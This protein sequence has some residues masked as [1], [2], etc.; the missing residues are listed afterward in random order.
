MRA[1]PISS[2]GRTR[3]GRR[4]SVRKQR[5]LRRTQS[6]VHGYAAPGGTVSSQN[7]CC[8]SNRTSISRPP[9][10]LA[11]GRLDAVLGYSWRTRLASGVISGQGPQLL[12]EAHRISLTPP[13][14]AAAVHKTQNRDSCER[15]FSTCSGDA[16]VLAPVG[17]C[18]CKA[19]RHLVTFRH[20]VIDCHGSVGKC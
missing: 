5:E 19:A 12:Q 11:A 9:Q 4:E 10:L 3:Y 1:L 14:Y 16:Q 6:R 8:P 7:Y 18:N 2:V 15:H 13:F 17:A 20:Q